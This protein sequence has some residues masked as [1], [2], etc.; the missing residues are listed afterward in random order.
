MVKTANSKID[1][2]VLDSVLLMR[3]SFTGSGGAVM[4]ATHSQSDR[5]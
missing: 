2:P 3:I 5:Q 4:T 1:S